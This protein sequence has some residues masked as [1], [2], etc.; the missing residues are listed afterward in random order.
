MNYELAKELRDAGFPALLHYSRIACRVNGC[1]QYRDDPV[2]KPTLSELIEACAG[3]FQGLIHLPDGWH[4]WSTVVSGKQDVGVRDL[5]GMPVLYDDL[6]RSKGNASPEE[7][8][9]RL[10]L[11]LKQHEA[12][13]P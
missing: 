6:I 9:A 1:W 13:K 11:A 5:E 8:V 7:A 10:W 4:A 12:P 3:E 2:H